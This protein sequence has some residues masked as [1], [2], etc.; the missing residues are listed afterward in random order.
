MFQKPNSKKEYK[1]TTT[2][3]NIDFSYDAA[4]AQNYD[5]STLKA[6]L[7]KH[8]VKDLITLN[9]ARPVYSSL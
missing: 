6:A 2:R 7:S 3:Q 8:C 5:S 9:F 1:K 4:I